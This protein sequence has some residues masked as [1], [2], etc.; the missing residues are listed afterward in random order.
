MTSLFDLSLEFF[1]LKDL[2]DND[3]EVNEETG[4]IVDNTEVLNK[5]FNDLTLSFEDKLDNSQRYC[6]TLEG[7][8][9][10]LAKEI[11]RLQAKKQA[12]ENRA[13][14]LSKM[15]MN[16]ILSSGQTKFKT[17]LYS[18]SIKT[19]ESVEVRDL[20]EIPR[21]FLRIKKEADKIQLKKALK[22]TTPKIGFVYKNKSDDEIYTLTEI[23]DDKYLLGAKD[24][25]NEKLLTLENLQNDFILV[26]G[27]SIDGVFLTEKQSLGVR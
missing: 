19:S 14:R 13:D 11:K 24:I 4:E 26:K 25:T 22:D 17:Q 1:A 18:F 21:E 16:A 8:A 10:I 27:F 23:E 20:D 5:L 3:L 6:L 15:M 2:I 12:L 7:E 9:D